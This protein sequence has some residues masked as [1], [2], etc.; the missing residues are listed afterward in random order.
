MVELTEK[1]LQAAGGWK[2]WKQAQS[3]HSMGRVSDATYESS[4]LKGYVQDGSRRFMAGFR[5]RSRTDFENLCACVLSRKGLVCEHSL[6]VGLGVLR[7]SPT[8]STRSET[9]GTRAVAQRPH[10][11]SSAPCD[12]NGVIDIELTSNGLLLKL[13]NFRTDESASFSALLRRSGCRETPRGN[14]EIVGN[15]AAAQF[16][17]TKL[18][19]W[20]EKG[21]AVH[22]QP[23]VEKLV[24]SFIRIDPRMQIAAESGGWLDARI[25]FAAGNAAVFS[26]DD[27]RKLL[28]GGRSAV[29]LGD[30]RTAV[31]DPTVVHELEATLRECD[32]MQER[33][34]FRIRE[35]HREFL[36]AS[37]L[38][39]AP[40]TGESV[41]PRGALDD[42]LRPYQREGVQWMRGL[43]KKQWGGILAD[44]MGLGKTVQALALIDSLGGSALVVCPS[45][46]LWNWQREAERFSPGRKVQ[47]IEGTERGRVFDAD[48]MTDGLFITSYGLLRR[49][50]DKYRGRSFQAV[51]LDEAQHIKN[52][53]SQ[54]ARAA[55][56]L[57]AKSRFVLTGTPVENS[58]SDLWSLFEFILPGY[59]GSAKDFAERYSKPLASQPDPALSAR[60]ARRI[61]PFVLRRLKRDVVTELPEKVEQVV[62]C[63]LT[64]Q[65]RSAYESLRRAAV[66][67]VD[68]LRKAQGAGAARMAVLTAIL[69]LR[70]ACCDVRLL[71]AEG[72]VASASAKIR[73]L[74]ELLE[75]ARDG[76]HR[77]L[78]FSQ[79]TSMLDLIE[80]SLVESGFT[81]CRLDGET[82]DRMAVVDRFQTDESVNAFLISLKSGGVGLNLTGADTVIHF[83][84]WWNPAVEAQATDRAHRIGQTRVVSV[85]KLVAQHTIE[86]RVLKL[87]DRKRALL[88]GVMESSSE[89]LTEA[90]FQELLAESPE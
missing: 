1:L 11:D 23:A 79:F 86:E 65:Q 89:S 74:L 59:L 90:D 6:A 56:N 34:G 12:S 60:L 43:A 2:A 49:D 36:V 87:Q 10:S 81:Y 84:P 57:R 78:V 21:V 24:G 42:V 51:L 47:I 3:F 14:W 67:R 53:D 83:D 88:A 25:H 13:C 18:P 4:V 7:P 40:Q 73:M 66:D 70:Q 71:G 62:Y 30:G 37:G 41:P 32:P 48:P 68:D 64:D 52:P 33:G 69:R 28:A 82:R 9:V 38:A 85:I 20:Q 77:T 19:Q 16:L 75:T 26:M 63:E 44:D 15:D 46:L 76:G 31:L 55:V 54:N 27:I 22:L 45:S 35:I 5:I 29:R 39:P 61:R 17:T 50:V 58:L 8:D 80:T 72:D